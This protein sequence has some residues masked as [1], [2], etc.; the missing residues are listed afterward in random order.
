MVIELWPHL[1]TGNNSNPMDIT[2]RVFANLKKELSFH[3]NK[4]QLTQETHLKILV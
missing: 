2:V 1:E 3:T 4:N